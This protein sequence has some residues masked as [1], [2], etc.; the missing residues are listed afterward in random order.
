MGRRRGRRTRS[1][2]PRAHHDALDDWELAHSPYAIEGRIESAAR[3]A[4]GLTRATGWRRRLGLTLVW[5]IFV[6]FT[7]GLIAVA[8]IELFGR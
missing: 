8:L 4:R 6:P 1:G 5:V 2:E 7:T 3:F